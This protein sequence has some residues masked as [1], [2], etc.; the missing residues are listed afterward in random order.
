[1]DGD[2]ADL[3]ARAVDDD[4][5]E[6]ILSADLVAMCWI[7]GASSLSAHRVVVDL[8]RAADHD[9]LGQ[10]DRVGSFAQDRALRSLLAARLEP[11]AHVGKVAVVDHVAERLAGFDSLSSPSWVKRPSGWPSRANT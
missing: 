5:S 4:R 7:A 10:V 11:G 9:E 8:F 6:A 3:V 1:M 2:D